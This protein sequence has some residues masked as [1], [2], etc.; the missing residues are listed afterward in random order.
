[1]LPIPG[2]NSVEVED[3]MNEYRRYFESQ[4]SLIMNRLQSEAEEQRMRIN[5]QFDNELRLAQAAIEQARNQ[6]LLFIEHQ[7]IQRKADLERKLQHEFRMLDIKS[8]Q[9]TLMP[10]FAKPLNQPREQMVAGV[11]STSLGPPLHQIPSLTPRSHSTIH[12]E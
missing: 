9:S 6:A 10:C 8:M 2:N 5:F 4:T 3:S 12:R 7:M 1:M 11:F